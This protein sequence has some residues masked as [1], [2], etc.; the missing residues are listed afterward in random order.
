VDPDRP[1]LRPTSDLAIH[2]AAHAARPDVRAVAHAHLPASLALTLAGEV[3]DPAILPE[4]GLLLPRLPFLPLMAMGSRALADAIG[5]A[6]SDPGDPADA[7]LL[8]RHGAVAVG[9]TIESAVDR[10]ELVEL[11][12]R[13]W[14]DAR[15]LGWTPP[16]RD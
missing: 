6:L 1:D 3:P 7:V 15:L 4:T 14:R 12:C 11:L 13:V 2:R 9:A 8:E 16:D 10:L 5:A